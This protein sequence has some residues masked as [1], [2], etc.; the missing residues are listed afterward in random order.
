MQEGCSQ[1]QLCPSDC[2]SWF[3][4]YRE[5]FD[6]L[7]H[8][9]LNW[10]KA[11]DV[12]GGIG[13]LSVIIRLAISFLDGS[14]KNTF[15]CPDSDFLA[16][17]CLCL[18]WLIF[19]HGSVFIIEGGLFVRFT[20]RVC[21]QRGNLIGIWYLFTMTPSLQSSCD[22]LCFHSQQP[23]FFCAILPSFCTLSAA[24]QHYKTHNIFT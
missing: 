15:K 22:A 20:S 16:L 1:A 10:K 3:L 4:S 5:V 8:P 14:R 23:T 12:A 18:L 2:I 7:M 13:V 17:F 9:H 11:V 21:I 6:M 24:I 19:L